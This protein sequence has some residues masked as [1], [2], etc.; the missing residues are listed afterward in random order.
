MLELNFS[1]FPEIKTKRLLLRR[2]TDADATALLF[3]RSDDRVMQYIGREKT[4]TLEEA[5][6]F[7]QKIN[8]SVDANESIMWAIA[9]LEDP[10]TMVGTICFWN[11]L[12]DHYRAEV[13]YVLHPD[14]WRKGIMKEAVQAVVDFGFNE[15]KLHG[16]EGHINP[17]N[18]VSGI[19]LE[20][21]GFVREA[22]FKE[23]F[24]FR[25]KFSDTA[26]YALLAK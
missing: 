11:I 6:A 21:C 7:I 18:A 25:G 3:L 20:K 8:A 24:C 22:Y 15:M 2:M 26:V 10:A 13:G 9:L 1:P 23:N 4:K 14:Q 19:V 17:E 12:T 5:T 16:I